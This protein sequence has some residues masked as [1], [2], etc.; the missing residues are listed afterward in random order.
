MLKRL[1]VFLAWLHRSPAFPWRRP[2]DWTPPGGVVKLTQAERAARIRVQT[3]SD[4]ELA[5]LWAAATPRERLFL[6]LG[7]NCGFA[8]A[9]VASLQL[10]EIHLRQPHGHYPGLDG[11]WIKRERGKNGVFGEWRLWPITV[12][13]IEWAL[14]RRPADTAETALLLSPRTGRPLSEPT[15][16]NNRNPHI[17]NAWARL[18]ARV[19]K[20]HPEF[21]RLAFK[22]IRKTAANLIRQTAG[23]E[24][25]AVFMCHGKPVSDEL[26]DIYTERPF[27][28]VFEALDAVAARLAPMLTSLEDP[29]PPTPPSPGA[30][31][32][33]GKV[34]RIRQLRRQGFTVVKIAQMV[35]VNRDTVL[36]YSRSME[37]PT[38]EER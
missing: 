18:T 26:S 23:G 10:S 4:A 22:H 7:L 38:G 2:E 14:A 17:S 8:A 5:L 28:R 37:H 35:G 9:E 25:S 32:A 19:K 15:R 21:R 11:S 20:E 30:R 36:Q 31:L 34:E 12:A 3:Y 29:F 33:Q 16:S 6:V 24:V 1:R 13:G 27:D